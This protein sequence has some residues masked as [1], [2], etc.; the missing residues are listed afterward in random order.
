MILTDPI[1][2]FIF[3]SHTTYISRASKSS[4]LYWDQLH[5]VSN[6]IKDRDKD[7]LCSVWV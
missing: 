7:L 4:I 2:G 5:F 1:L 6:H 3:I